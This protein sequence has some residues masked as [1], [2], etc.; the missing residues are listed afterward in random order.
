MARPVPHSLFMS[1]LARWVQHRL[2]T[3]IK[4][5]ALLAAEPWGVYA[6][7]TG[8]EDRQIHVLD[9][10]RGVI[11]RSLQLPPKAR[12][13]SDYRH[14][15][16]SPDG[17]VVAAYNAVDSTFVAWSMNDGDLL[18]TS[19]GVGRIPPAMAMLPGGRLAVC[20]G[21]RIHFY[22][23]GGERLTTTPVSDD[24]RS[25]LMFATPGVR[26]QLVCVAVF[27][28]GLGG[29]HLHTFVVD[30][31]EITL[32]KE[33]PY[34]ARPDD[35]HDNKTIMLRELVNIPGSTERILVVA[36]E[37]RMER[38]AQTA[39][40]E[41]DDEYRTR[42]LAVDPKRGMFYPTEIELK[43]RHCLQIDNSELMLIDERG[44]RRKVI[45]IPLRVVAADWRL[46]G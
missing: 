3:E 40:W 5:P 8:W 46:T 20:D 26:P 13:G 14:F 23:L 33:G 6:L 39:E 38:R 35:A 18:H 28:K 37:E 36:E 21:P 32:R 25:L 42:I 31:G 24:L 19:E 16:F 22:Q 43:G 7:V 44:C 34:R 12:K 11:A 10:K 9:R 27:R 30:N 1:D 29:H 15:V 17:M 4:G 45:G 41:Y 2:S